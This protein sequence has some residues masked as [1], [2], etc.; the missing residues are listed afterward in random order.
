[1][2]AAA[3]QGCKSL[4]D[5]ESETETEENL[6]LN[7]AVLIAPQSARVALRPLDGSER[8]YRL[9][10]QVTEQGTDLIDLRLT[11]REMA[12]GDFLA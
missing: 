5:A 10:F 6:P 11:W 12:G 7:D 9:D 2:P 4:H 8:G 1:M 3:A